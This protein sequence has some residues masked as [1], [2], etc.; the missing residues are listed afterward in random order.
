MRTSKAVLEDKS[1]LRRGMNR[2]CIIP[3]PNFAPTLHR[4]TTQSLLLEGMFIPTVAFEGSCSCSCSGSGS[5]L[6]CAVFALTLAS[7]LAFSLIPALAL[8]SAQA[9]S[10]TPAFALALTAA[11]AFALALAPALAP[12]PPALGTDHPNAN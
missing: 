6:A 1:D 8:A 3:S 11:L 2:T 10:L 7:A 12:P 4:L 9:F 5:A